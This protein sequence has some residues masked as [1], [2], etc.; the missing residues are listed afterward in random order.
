MKGLG[1]KQKEVLNDMAE[2]NNVIRG[3][4]DHTLGNGKIEYQ[5]EDEE[6]DNS[7]EKLS[8]R[9]VESLIDRSVFEVEE[10]NPCLH[11]DIITLRL[12]P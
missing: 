10:F 12:K 6:G 1:K 8:T 3:I 4:I 11:I 5:L 7:F 2:N 9:F